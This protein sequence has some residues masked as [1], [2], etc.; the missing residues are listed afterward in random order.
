[1]PLSVRYHIEPT[2][3]L[4]SK[5]SGTEKKVKICFYTKKRK[6]RAWIKHKKITYLSIK[7]PWNLWKTKAEHICKFFYSERENQGCISKTFR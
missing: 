3:E 1:M 5:V 6:K 4:D 2:K 7:R